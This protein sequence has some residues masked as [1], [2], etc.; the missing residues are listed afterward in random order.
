MEGEDPGTTH[1][2]D[3][4]HWVAIYTQMLEFKERLLGR[5]RDDSEALP[6]PARQKVHDEDL[7][8]LER[9]RAKVE[10]RLQFW[11]QRHWELAGIDLDPSA[12]TIVFQG[13]AVD[14]TPREMQLL[15]ILLRNPNRYISSVE[16][17][18]RAWHDSKLAPE[19]VRSYVT[20][21]RRK[22]GDAGVPCRLETRPRRGYRLVFA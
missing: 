1:V 12:R 11:R 16:I 2:E 13:A 10:V 6:A 8:T 18:D 20:R 21:L 22:L 14:L 3:A 9:E 19:Q 7:I 4:R 5:A 15:E 17:L